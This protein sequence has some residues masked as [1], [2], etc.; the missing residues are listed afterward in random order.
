MTGARAALAP[1]SLFVP[2]MFN[3]P[4]GRAHGGYVCGRLAALAASHLGGQVRVTLHLPIPLEVPLAYRISGVRGYVAVDDQLAATVSAAHRAIPAIRAVSPA[5]AMTAQASADRRGH[6]FPT[7]FACGPDRPD[8]LRLLP[9]PAPGQVG[10]TACKWSPGPAVCRGGGSVPAEIVWSAL[11]CP[12]GWTCD[13]TREPRVLTSMTAVVEA[14][15]REHGSYV[16]GGQLLGIR[17]RTAT[18]ATAI[19]SDQGIILARALA[20]WTTVEPSA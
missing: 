19:F 7:C 6:P 10:T 4:P 13:L 18:T 11:D 9:G 3:G 8:G 15:P 2:R 16:I 20:D 14:L 12:G 17:G 1:T 5:D